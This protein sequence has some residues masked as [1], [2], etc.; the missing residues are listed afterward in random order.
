MGRLRSIWSERPVARHIPKW[1]AAAFALSALVSVVI[2]T[3]PGSAP[4]VAH[5]AT[6]PK[7]ACRVSSLPA[8][9]STGRDPLKGVCT[10]LTSR[11][12][13]VQ[14]ALFNN[15]NGRTYLLSNG[16]DTQY[17]ASIVKVDILASWLYRY[18]SSGTKIPDDI[19]YSVKYL[20]GLMIDM[21]DNAAATGLFY[22]GGGCNAVSTF[23]TL[24]PLTSTTVGCE[25]SNYY[26]WGNTT[27][28]AS[29]QVKLMKLYAYGSGN[30]LGS[31]ARNYGNSLMKMVDQTQRWGISCGPW[32]TTCNP[33]NY[34]PP[35]DSVTVALKNG[36]KTLPTCTKPVTDCPWQVN[37]TGWVS[38]KGRN[39]TLTV[40]TTDDPVGSGG[41]AGFTYG[42]DTIQG[43]SK[44]IWANLG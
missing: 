33:P 38:G 24:I 23:N 6:D 44:M 17:T 2:E 43:V 20:M 14:V 12:G 22:F 11:D 42:I 39:Y 26:G 32:G 21:S 27:T 25:S 18:Q 9:P 30:I 34:A 19:P 31:D 10:Y 40:L 37:S 3:V 4:A 13:V 41:T 35:L 5:P 15:N 16:D 1:V 28:T 29:D 36:W 7:S 8:A